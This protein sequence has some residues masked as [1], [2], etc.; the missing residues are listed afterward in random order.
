MHTRTSRKKA[1]E[2]RERRELL[3]AVSS[4]LIGAACG[5]WTLAPVAMAAPDTEV[6]T[7]GTVVKQTEGK[8]DIGKVAIDET[9]GKA[10]LNI[11]QS[12]D[13]AII[14]WK[15]FNVGKDAT[16][17]FNHYKGTLGENGNAVQ[18][19]AG[20]T[21][22]RVIGNDMSQIR[23]HINAVG[24]VILVNPNGIL[25]AEGSEVNAA[26][27]IAST[28]ML[29]EDK[30]INGTELRFLQ[31]NK[32]NNNITVLG[33]LNAGINSD[34]LATGTDYQ[35]TLAD[36]TLNIGNRQPVTGFS[37]VGNK[38]ML[39]A[40][41]DV[42]VGKSG[43]I[44]AHTETTVAGGGTVG[45]EGFSVGGDSSTRESSV[46][47]RA[48]QNHDDLAIVDDNIKAAA[49]AGNYTYNESEQFTASTLGYTAGVDAASGKYLKTAKV[50]LSNDSTINSQNVGVYWDSDV[51]SAGINGTTTESIGIK[52]TTHTKFTQK[53]YTNYSTE[54][55]KLKSHVNTSSVTVNTYTKN[56]NTNATAND[57]TVGSKSD[58]VDHTFATLVND[59]YQLQAIQDVSAITGLTGE[60]EAAKADNSYY[61]NLG[62]VYAQG[63]GI[64]A[65]DTTTWTDGSGAKVGFNSIGN[66]SS[67]SFAGGYTGNG[68]SNT[69]GIYDMYVNRTGEDYVGLFASTSGASIWS[70]S[71]IDSNINGKN[72]VGGI[73]GSATN[74]KLDGNTTRKR[75]IASEG[76]TTKTP[77]QNNVTGTNYV[78]GIAGDMTSSTMRHNVNG[79]QIQGTQYVGGLTGHVSGEKANWLGYAIGYY[80]QNKGYY[81]G[82]ETVT[83]GYGVVKGT[84]DVGGLAGYVGV[85]NSSSSAD[86]TTTRLT[87]KSYSN[88]QV[89]GKDNVGGLVGTMNGT[90]GANYDTGAYTNGSRLYQVY[91]TNE[92]TTL[93]NKVTD[94]GKHESTQYTGAGS[95]IY[96]KVT[97]T[98][99]KV[100]GLVGN[101]QGG[102]IEESYNAGNVSGASY[103]G[104][105]A[106]YM[107]DGFI[108]D[109]YS[110]DNNTVLMTSENDAEYYGFSYKDSS[111]TLYRYTYDQDNQVWNQYDSAGSLVASSLSTEKVLEQAPEAG[112]LYNNRLAYRDATVSATGDYVG[113][114][115]GSVEGGRIFDAYAAGKVS[116][117]NTTAKNVGGLLGYITNAKGSATNFYVTTQN[118][119]GTDISGLGTTGKAIGNGGFTGNVGSATAIN[120]WQAQNLSTAK[121]A[122]TSGAEINGGV[123]FISGGT[124]QDSDWMLYSNSATPTLKAFMNW[125]NISRQYV[126]DGTVHNLITTDVS[127]YYGGA[128]FTDG[129]A[130]NVYTEGVKK[131]SEVASGSKPSEFVYKTN[132]DGITATASDDTSHSSFYQYENSNMWSPQHGYYTDPTAGL[133]ITPKT[134]TAKLTG[135]KT[136]G[137]TVKGYYYNDGTANYIYDVDNSVWKVAA[138][139]TDLTGYYKL[140]VTGSDNKAVKL[141][142]ENGKSFLVGLDKVTIG[143]TAS[144]TTT[145]AT[146]MLGADVDKEQQLSAGTYSK[147]NGKFS[148][149]GDVQDTYT[150]SDGKTTYNTYNYVAEYDGQL[151]V[152]KAD[153][154]V[155]ATGSKSYGDVNGKITTVNILGVGDTTSDKKNN[156][157]LKS[158]DATGVTVTDAAGNVTYDATKLTGYANS[159]TNNTLVAT[160]SASNTKKGVTTTST[161]IDEGTWVKGSSVDN[162]ESYTLGKG[163]FINAKGANELTS[164]NYNIIYVANAT[165]AQATAYAGKSTTGTA[166]LEA[167][168][169]N[170]SYTINPVELKYNVVGSHVYGATS[171]AKEYDVE[172]AEAA[173]LKN[174]DT[175]DDVVTKVSLD[176]LGY[177]AASTK[178]STDTHVARD[179]EGNVTAVVNEKIEGGNWQNDVKLN[180]ANYKLSVNNLKY[181]VTPATLTLTTGDATKVYGDTTLTQTEANELTGFLKGEAA[182]TAYDASTGLYKGETIT[183]EGTSTNANISDTTGYSYTYDVKDADGNVTSTIDLT[184]ATADAGTYEHASHTTNQTLY[185]NDYDVVYNEGTVTITPKEV[186]VEVDANTKVYGNTTADAAFTGTLTGIIEADKSKIT[187]LSQESYVSTG[188]EN[189]ANVGDYA[190]TIDSTEAAKSLGGNY[191]LTSVTNGKLT[192]NKRKVSYTVDNNSREY[193]ADSPDYAYSGS[194]TLAKDT[195]DN[196]GLMS[197]DEGKT[198][199]QNAYTLKT[200]AP[201]T[202][203]VGTYTD[204]ITVAK[205]RV[206]SALG[207]NYELVNVEDG[208]MT[209]RQ[210]E[211]Y[212]RANDV[213]YRQGDEAIDTAVVTGDIVNRHGKV[214]TSYLT[215]EDAITWTKSDQATS[216]AEIGR[217][218][219]E[220]SGLVGNGNYKIAEKDPQWYTNATAFYI[221]ARGVDNQ[222]QYEGAKD[223]FE[224]GAKNGESTFISMNHGGYIPEEARNQLRLLTIEDSGINV[225]NAIG[226]IDSI[227]IAPSSYASNNGGSS[228]VAPSATLTGYRGGS[229][230]GVATN[231]APAD[232]ALAADGSRLGG[233]FAGELYAGDIENNADSDEDELKKQV[234]S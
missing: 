138:A 37:M 125:I 20:V 36:A 201:I 61:G 153:L 134:I 188:L 167:N 122:N 225:T 12:A 24:S 31:D 174:G 43:E 110:A 220:G 58:G 103:V 112:R 221:R 177:N 102:S 195:G 46:V 101:L 194:F 115:V 86:T 209:I 114:V 7:G 214:V 160:E 109:S 52:G 175:I 223:S 97:A 90:G 124:N 81:S 217:Y 40:D 231:G 71:Q 116:T 234:E 130:Q 68:G 14:N 224:P 233:S 157:K 2:A 146:A 54:A 5:L 80:S 121:S 93:G 158:W 171:I 55:D 88:G 196:T 85:I 45:T 107:K 182:D 215:D 184:S 161:T 96:G 186:S 213:T 135:S 84:T 163:T 120:L 23:G 140:T 172:A 147:T 232:N 66:G 216:E 64:A 227:T 100:G 198:L 136:Y 74:T 105:I 191:K 99:D 73:V 181:T 141:L 75:V 207:N 83:Q 143:D 21:L 152:N 113:G 11:N 69:Y 173:M 82:T 202:T 42:A 165:D 208:D 200:T 17:N 30:F 16:V 164:T 47:I 25:F 49:E 77:N 29:N 98:G 41:G 117:K 178:V 39:V 1:R 222:R 19:T 169:A 133:I 166:L 35:K 176:S 159:A 119:T 51:T 154:I 67:V 211:L 168:K 187:G 6:P 185:F 111:G 18:N 189:R 129:K 142:D 126:Y 151:T 28:E 192:V 139:S 203:D 123:S 59:V 108:I 145:T 48:D 137:D 32:T 92:A 132:T 156:G 127:N 89:S 210:A 95:S 219:I 170:A 44:N 79:A 15:T 76:I 228:I 230:N 148:V 91:N 8:V 149:T 87:G 57:F 3:R 27:I 150:T 78:G 34:Y 63:T 106:G 218:S 22:N 10:T 190:I 128:F 65:A 204:D 50:Y 9:T 199:G 131:V 144:T 226:A 33:K 38:I 60:T 193:L 104:G 13:R 183:T 212:Y 206:Q 56:T 205:D 70:T 197:W 4:T 162:P 179:A 72:Y 118:V 229:A 180:N 155:T 53:D 94:L 62:A 26:G